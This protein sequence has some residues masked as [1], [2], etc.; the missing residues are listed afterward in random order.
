[1]NVTLTTCL[2]RYVGQTGIRHACRLVS[3]HTVHR[4]ACGIT[5]IIQRKN[6]EEAHDH[7]HVG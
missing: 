6:T 4:C 7:V 2:V 1:V 5:W 3:P